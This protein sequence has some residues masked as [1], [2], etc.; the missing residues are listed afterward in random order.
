M[1]QYHTIKDIAWTAGLLEG[2]GSFFTKTN[3]SIP[4][5][6]CEMT[7]L[8]VLERLESIWGGKIYVM[9]KRQEHWKQSWRW[10]ISNIYAVALMEFIKP[11]M[12]VRR[13]EK[14][15]QVVGTW[16]EYLQAKEEKYLRAS[17]A[18]VTYISDPTKSLRQ[19]AKE[20]DVSYETVRQWVAKM[21]TQEQELI[22]IRERE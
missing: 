19:V 13:Q 10:Q 2:E 7:D 8:D 3:S 1:E 16:A 4:I 22:P 12:S 14:I 5:V 15:T 21:N 18:A 20:Y 6:I 9:T 11:D 17:K